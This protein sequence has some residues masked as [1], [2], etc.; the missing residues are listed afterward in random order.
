MIENLTIYL[1]GIECF[2]E[3]EHPRKLP[4]SLYNLK[5]LYLYAVNLSGDF[6]FGMPFLALVIR[7]SPN[8]EKIKLSMVTTIRNSGDPNML[9]TKSNEDK[10]LDAGEDDYSDIQLKNLNELEI[11]NLDN[12][13]L[14]L[15]FLKLMLVK[16]PVLKTLRIFLHEQV[17]EDEELDMS[18]LLRSCAPASPVVEISLHRNV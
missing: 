8:L 12:K 2:G 10:E 9:G 4:N 11:E 15:E 5:Y 3:P 6:G 13:K 1:W 18:N 7:A 16:T 14:E 17:A